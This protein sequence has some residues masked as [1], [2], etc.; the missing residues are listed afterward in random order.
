MGA[1]PKTKNTFLAHAR[2]ANPREG[3]LRYR[4]K[5]QNDHSSKELL[6]LVQFLIQMLFKRALFQKI[7]G[8]MFSPVVFSR[9][10]G[11]LR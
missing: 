8:K 3:Q 7:F 2:T 11:I 4:N 5:V 10:G 6:D 1:T 9:N